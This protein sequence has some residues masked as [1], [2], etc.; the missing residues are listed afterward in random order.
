MD[1]I[2]H[3]VVGENMISMMDG[4]SGYN[5][6]AMH[7]DDRE[8]TNFTTPWGALMYAKMPFGLI[9]VGENFQRAI[10]ITFLG[11]RIM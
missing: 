3:K 8:K 6:V 4:F 10:K 9:N 5:Q 1:H 11:G 7:L 2:L